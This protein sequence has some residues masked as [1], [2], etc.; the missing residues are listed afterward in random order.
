[1]ECDVIE[2]NAIYVYTSWNTLHCI[3]S[4]LNYTNTAQ[5]QHNKAEQ[6][7]KNIH[8][9]RQVGYIYIYINTYINYITLHCIALHC[10]ALHCM[11]ACI[12]T[13]IQM[14][15]HIYAVTTNIVDLASAFTLISVQ[16]CHCPFSFRL[17]SP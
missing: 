1:M 9:H 14:Q 10:V 5:T 16:A 15:Q 17:Q 12:H 3:S 8:T 2:C 13:Y 7:N 4:A 6:N 11:H